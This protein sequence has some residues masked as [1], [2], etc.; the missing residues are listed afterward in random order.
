MPTQVRV[1]EYSPSIRQTRFHTSE[2]FETLYGG[3]AGGGKTTAIV[4]EAVTYALEFP[5]A[6]VYIFRRTIPELKQSV[7]PEIYKQCAKYID[8]GG[9]KYNSQDRVWVFR[10]GSTIQ[11]AYLEN[12]AD[13]FRYQSAEIH[14]LL[15]DELTHF[16]QEEYEYLKTRVRSTGEHPLKVMAATN[17]GNIG[18]GWVKAYFIDIAPSETIH[19]D[20]A[21][22]TRMFVPAKIDDHP[23]EA[24]RNSY[25]RQLDSL[26]DPELKRALRNGDWDLFSGQVFT[27]WNR[28]EHT[29]DPFPIPNHWTKWFSYDWGYN[30]YAAGTW[31]AR[32]PQSTRIYVYREFYPH[33][34]SASVQADTILNLTGT[35]HIVTW[36]ADPSLWK[37]HGNVETGESVGKIFERANLIF[38]PAN[39][40]RKSGL[41]AVHEALAPLPDGKPGLIVFNS[42]VNTIRTIPALPYD[43]NKAEDVDT[44]A[45]DH[46]YDTW[47]YGLVNQRPAVMPELKLNNEVISRRNRYR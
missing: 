13:M 36:W 11:L 26:S 22:N 43:R 31:F 12:A 10:N 39:N 42:C 28:E 30:T 33:A 46:L 18:H 3:A 34:M 21:G 2:A 5:K 7:Q 6:R 4:A 24:F 32:D 38:Q 9:M 25:G 27:E 29:C 40:D 20:K 47:R 1:P 23:I 37:Q 44:D 15:V 14:L 19:T 16:T 35:E 8:M 17:P 45:E 41:N